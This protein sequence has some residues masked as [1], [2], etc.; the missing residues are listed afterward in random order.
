MTKHHFTATK[1]RSAAG[2]SARRGQTMT[3]V[4][5]FIILC[6]HAISHLPDSIPQRQAVLAA[7]LLR[8]PANSPLAQHVRELQWHLQAHL[9]LSTMNQAGCSQPVPTENSTQ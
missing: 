8:A 7:L 9:R 6:Q 4:D 1:K 2:I 3:D 5:A